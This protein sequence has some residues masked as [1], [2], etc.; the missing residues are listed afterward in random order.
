LEDVIQ[1]AENMMYLSKWKSTATQFFN[2]VNSETVTG[3][4]E[5]RRLLKI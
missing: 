1:K 4:S 2:N 5:G 3:H